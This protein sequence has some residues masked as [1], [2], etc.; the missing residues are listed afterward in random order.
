MKI[1][2]LR[3]EEVTEDR[4]EGVGREPRLRVRMRGAEVSRESR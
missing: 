3:L 1:K 4:K 2:E